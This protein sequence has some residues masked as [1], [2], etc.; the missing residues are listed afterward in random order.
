MNID[1]VIISN[2][3]TC[4]IRS[5]TNKFLLPVVIYFI[6]D[7]SDSFCN[8]SCLSIVTFLKSCKLLTGTPFSKNLTYTSST[9]LVPT[10]V[11]PSAMTPIKRADLTVSAIL[12]FSS[13]VIATTKFLQALS[14]WYVFPKQT[15]CF[16]SRAHRVGKVLYSQRS[17]SHAM[18][19]LGTDSL[20]LL[21]N[22]LKRKGEGLGREN[23]T[24][25]ET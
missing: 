1:T 3:D 23:Q 15:P 11:V 10:S 21:M 6:Q 5:Q 25:D 20:V 4:P 12:H 8:T 17:L 22:V 18:L 16:F 14:V 7:F 2:R 13:S 19:R 24:Q 9:S